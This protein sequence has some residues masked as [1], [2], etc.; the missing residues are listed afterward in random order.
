MKHVPFHPPEGF[1]ARQRAEVL[2]A[3]RSPRRAWLAVA[4]SVAA[5]VVA[6]IWWGQEM[7]CATYACLLESTPAEEL[8][9]DW[10]LD[11]LS[12]EDLWLD[13]ASEIPHEL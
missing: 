11:E 2:A 13:L 7:P 9:V 12:E 3:V 8:P 5:L 1:Y 10:A 6:G 4:A